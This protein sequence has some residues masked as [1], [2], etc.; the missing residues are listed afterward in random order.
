MYLLVFILIHTNLIYTLIY[1]VRI[2]S[3]DIEAIGT[4]AVLFETRTSACLDF[5]YD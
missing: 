5:Y 2:S 3:E 4:E 1:V